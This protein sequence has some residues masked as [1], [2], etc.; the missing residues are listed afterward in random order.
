MKIFQILFVCLATFVLGQG[1]RVTYEYQFVPNLDKKDSLKKEIVYLD[2][3]KEGSQFFS[4]KKFESDS[5][6]DDY[7]KKM[8][9]TGSKNFNYKGTDAGLVNYQVKKSYPD[10]NTVLSIAINRN[11]YT[12]K[13]EKAM[14]WKIE[15]ETK[16]IDK[17]NAQKATLDFGG[18]SWTAWFT[19]EI[20]FQEGPYKFSGLPGLILEMEDVTKT[21]QYKFLGIKNFDD[22]IVKDSKDN[23]ESS[24]MI[25]GFGANQKPL[26]V[27]ENKFSQLWKEYKNDSVKDMRQMLGQGNVR[28]T[29][30]I[31]GKI[32]TDNAEMLRSMEKAQ[33]EQLKNNNNPLELTL[34]P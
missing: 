12:V 10:F 25:I 3:R 17:F 9:A 31:D 30:N 11:N 20:P 13:N 23:N 19:Q 1:T 16:K 8:R 18:R 28:V 33:K 32:V 5:L 26:E 6:R 7:F 21:H 29:M 4:Q 24:G 34:F 15:Q 27:S 2:I 22:I 14:A